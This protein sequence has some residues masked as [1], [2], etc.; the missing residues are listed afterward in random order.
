M[1]TKIKILLVIFNAVLVLLFTFILPIRFEEND[2]VMMLLFSSGSYTGHPENVL[3]FIN[4][5]YGSVLQVFYSV[6]PNYEWY[7]LFFLFFHVI[8][9]S[10]LSYEILRNQTNKITKVVL[11]LILYL[12]EV[13]LLFQLQFTT[14][15]ALLALSGLILLNKKSYVNYFL[16]ALFFITASL[17]RFE[18]AFLV[19][20]VIFPLFLKNYIRGNKNLKIKIVSSASLGCVTDK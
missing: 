19:L 2:D 11:M 3:V 18:A 5:I 15:A 4:Y 16:G 1:S 8:S 10:V 20:L 9:V 7:T 17:I 6:L 13:R 14:T 12:F